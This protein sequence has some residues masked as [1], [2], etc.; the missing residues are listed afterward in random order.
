MN[1]DF[2]PIKIDD[3]EAFLKPTADYGFISCEY[4]FAN[5]FMWGESFGM[6]WCDFLD[7]PLVVLHDEKVLYFPLSPKLN[8][9]NLIQLCHAYR[10]Q[11][12]TGS[13]FQV[14]VKFLEDNPELSEFFKIREDRNFADYLHKSERLTDLSGKKLRKKRNLISQFRRNY[15][16]YE[17]L[18]LTPEL[19]KRCLKLAEENPLSN[20]EEHQQ[21]MQALQNGFTNFAELQLSGRVIRYRDHTVAFTV[22][23]KHIDGNY[24]IHF[25]KFDYDFKGSA[26][27]VDW[28]T[29]E[30]LKDKCEYINREQDLG[31]QGLRKAKLSYDP[32]ILLVN[33]SL[34]PRKNADEL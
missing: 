21:E 9:E 31:I 2:K 32:D 4:S 25:E 3:R 15:S 1:L 13:F 16:D 19:F 11:G 10:E 8:G 17:N 20:E 23:S 6:E 30:V 22:F 24:L 7:Y 18:P 29:A 33:Y 27:I 34:I 28:A 14:P 5:F 12:G 26:Q